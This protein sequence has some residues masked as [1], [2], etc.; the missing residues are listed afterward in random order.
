MRVRRDTEERLTLEKRG[1]GRIWV[2]AGVNEKEKE[3]KTVVE[4]ESESVKTAR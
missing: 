2:A 3:E 1:E 4:M